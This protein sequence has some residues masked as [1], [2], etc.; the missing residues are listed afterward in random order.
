MG[1]IGNDGDV[2]IFGANYTGNPPVYLWENNLNPVSTPTPTVTPI[3]YTITESFESGLNGWIPDYSIHCEGMG[4]CAQPFIWHI[5]QS[6]VQAQD[7]AHSLEYF[8]TGA[9]DDGTTWIVREFRV[10]PG[11]KANIDLSFYLWSPTGD[12]ATGWPVMKYIGERKPEYEVDF[13]RTGRTGEVAGWKR[14]DYT[15]KVT[16]STGSIYIALGISVTWEADRTYY[17]DNVTVKSDIP[18]DTLP[19]ISPTPSVPGDI[20]GD[21]D[22]DLSDLTTLLTNFG[23]SGTSLPG[24]I[25]SNGDVDLADLTTL[26]SN[27]GR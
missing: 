3:V 20:D 16:S 19:V 9:N 18:L 2:D 7:G 24:D 6:T 10:P 4:Q 11:T 25:D 15:K 27:F 22:I 14:Y 5:E 23:R 21:G 26:L 1:D 17:I 8:L 13:D 12:D